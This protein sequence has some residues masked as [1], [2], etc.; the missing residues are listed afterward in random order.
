VGGFLIPRRASLGLDGVSLD[1][2][3]EDTTEHEGK[4]EVEQPEVGPQCESR[5]WGMS[6][7]TSNR[8]LRRKSKLGKPAHQTSGS[9]RVKEHAENKFFIGLCFRLL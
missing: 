5:T 8:Q 9:D 6:R 4:R 3:T 7:T 2:T 1:L